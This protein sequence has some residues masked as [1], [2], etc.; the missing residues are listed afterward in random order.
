VLI[1]CDSVTETL[2]PKGMY[3]GLIIALPRWIFADME[4]REMKKRVLP[5]LG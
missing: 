5:S 2:T 4:E 1:A 3:N